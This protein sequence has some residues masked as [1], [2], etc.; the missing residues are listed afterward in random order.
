M[1][2]VV[3]QQQGL[4]DSENCLIEGTVFNILGPYM[5]A[6]QADKAGLTWLD[7]ES[8]ASWSHWDVYQL[9]EVGYGN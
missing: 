8:D 1:F 6:K 3:T 4:F 2:V 5:T 9:K 7:E